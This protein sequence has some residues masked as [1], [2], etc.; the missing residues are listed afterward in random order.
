MDAFPGRDELVRDR[1]AGGHTAAI[2]T[3]AAAD[4]ASRRNALDG[5]VGLGLGVADEV[6]GRVHVR[7]VVFVHHQ[8]IGQRPPAVPVRAPQIVEE[9]RVRGVIRHVF[10]ES[11]A[12]VHEP[13]PTKRPQKIVDIHLFTSR[14][15]LAG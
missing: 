7:A 13:R 9:F 1:S 10:L 12:Q 4:Q 5:D 6:S 2:Q 3:R 14:R 8:L 15:E 11:L